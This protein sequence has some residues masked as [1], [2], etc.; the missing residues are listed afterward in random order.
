MTSRGE[1]QITDLMDSEL[2]QLIREFRKETTPIKKL[3]TCLSHQF[4]E[5]RGKEWLGEL[6]QCAREFYADPWEDAAD[7]WAFDL[8]VFTPHVD[9][10]PLMIGVR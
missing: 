8:R 9:L 3:C 2:A 1:R 10:K 7:E 5:C 4:V 6:W